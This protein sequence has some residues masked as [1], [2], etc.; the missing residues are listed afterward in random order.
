[1]IKEEIVKI[2][3]S[4]P[5]N[6]GRA[7]DKMLSGKKDQSLDEVGEIEG[8]NGD[9]L[10]LKKQENNLKEED[11]NHKDDADELELYITNDGDLYRQQY[12]PILKNLT[13]KK[14]RGVYNSELAVKLF[15]YLVV[16]GAKKYVKEMSSSLPWNKMF[17]IPTRLE[18]AKR[19]RDNFERDFEDEQYTNFVPKKYR[20]KEL[21]EDNK[22]IKLTKESLS[23][24]VREE[25]E[26][27]L[28]EEPN[29]SLNG[30]EEDFSEMD[31]AIDEVLVRRGEKND[32]D[33]DKSEEDHSAI[34]ESVKITKKQK[35]KEK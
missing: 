9:T 15:M 12:E 33:G 18:V 4:G 2:E 8:S 24:I 17:S 22:N 14:A 6:M 25:V 19:L 1:M 35:N 28:K 31:N 3:E 7:L 20:P 32:A 34:E 21:R 30:S 13:A 26:K 11:E 5:G 16:N 10:L 23:N 27:V 29:Q